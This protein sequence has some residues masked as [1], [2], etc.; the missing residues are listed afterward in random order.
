M[1][2]AHF[3]AAAAAIKIMMAV[4]APAIKLNQR[5][6]FSN[7]LYLSSLSVLPVSILSLV[8]KWALLM[9]Y[10]MRYHVVMSLVL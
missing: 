2:T 5:L 4:E 8:S 9:M 6:L 3:A 1:S 10:P 7:P